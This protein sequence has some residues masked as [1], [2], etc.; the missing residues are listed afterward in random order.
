[1]FPRMAL[2]L[3]VIA[4]TLF[5]LIEVSS[6]SLS[7]TDVQSGLASTATVTLDVA[8]P[9]AVVRVN[10]SSSNPSV[11]SVPSSVEVPRGARTTTFS[12]RSVRGAAGCTTIS[13]RV[14]TTTRTTQLFVVPGS[15]SSPVTLTLSQSSIAGGGSLTGRVVVAQPSAVGHVVQ[16]SSS[17]PS[18][19]VPASVTL[20]PN[21]IGVAEATFNIGTAVVAPSTCSVISA[22]FEGSPASRKLL[23]VFSISG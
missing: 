11:A 1:M 13:A 23:K 3:A 20:G 17:N 5:A 19:T 7:P 18:V 15:P 16:L 8:S 22:S 21:E 6:L 10:L 12:V 4:P 14:N 9:R 2:G